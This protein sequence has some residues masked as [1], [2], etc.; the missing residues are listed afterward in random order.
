MSDRSVLI[1][2]TVVGRQ[3]FPIDMLRY[4]GLHPRNEVDANKITTTIL[5]EGIGE[6]QVEMS[7]ELSRESSDPSWQPKRE[8]W[9]RKFGWQV[10][11][12]EVVP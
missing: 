2:V 7:I 8:R 1:I 9:E 6:P 10:K 5:N 12:V 11:S 3:A 4:D